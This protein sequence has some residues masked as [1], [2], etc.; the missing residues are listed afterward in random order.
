M[1]EI[2]EIKK[3]KRGGLR[4]GA[5][6]PRKISDPQAAAFE[7]ATRT[8]NTNSSRAWIYMPTLQP[9]SEFGQYERTELIRKAHWMYNN[10]GIAARAIDSVARYSAPLT[11]QARTADPEFNKAV[12]RLFEDSCGTAA[13]GFDAAAEVN[14]YEAQA[15]ILRQVALDGDFFWQKIL[16]RSGRGMVRFIAGTSIANSGGSSTSGDWHDGVQADEFG[17]PIAFNVIESINPAKTTIVSADELH[18]VRKHYRR[19]YLRSPSWLA[20]ACNHLQDVSEILAFEK[21]SVKLN[22]QIAF[23]ITSPEAG[24]IGL[25][26][27]L[28]KQTFQDVGEV[29]VDKLYNSSGIPQLKP[30]EE[31]KSFF[32]N[33]P[34]VNFQ[35]FLNYLV[36]DIAWGMGLSP[37]L[38][39][40]ITNSGGANTRFLLED[41]NFF[42]AEC[43]SL[44]IEQF[45][46]PFWTFWVWNEIKSGRLNYR[47]DDWW[48]VEFIPPKRPSVDL[49]RE[50]SLYL[51]LVRSGLMTRKR[52]F[53]MLGMD[54]E[55][56]EDDLIASAVRFKKKCEAAGINPLE[57]IPPPPGSPNVLI[58]QQDEDEPPKPESERTR[59][60]T[61]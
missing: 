4:P 19:G 36:R 48:R 43:Q 27:G 55:T 10:L 21:S 6:R 37:E 38:L 12:E 50:G 1:A 45:C 11:P 26:A 53:S 23:V 60:D 41:A 3:S 47:G 18:Q 40:D 33:H 13:F 20:R 22:S 57:V 8:S 52:Y 54:D 2:K 15:Y 44:L 7:A 31:L 56:E 30:G 46:R 28:Q 51:S 59:T 5:G 61:R 58:E 39:W 29:T 16:S 34:N 14:F 32:N 17:R 42:F 35:S 25:G 49:G 24:R 9:R